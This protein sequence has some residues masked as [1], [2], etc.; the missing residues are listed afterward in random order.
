MREIRD[1]RQKLK[2]KETEKKSRKAVRIFV[3]SV[4]LEMIDNLP[5]MSPSVTGIIDGDFVG[6]PY[7]FF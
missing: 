5:A 3:K 1:L 4:S 7:V 6:E 2:L